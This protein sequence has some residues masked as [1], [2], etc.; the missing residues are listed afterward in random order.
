[1]ERLSP[2]PEDDGSRIPPVEKRIYEKPVAWL[3]GRQLLNS[4]KGALLYSALGSKLDARDWMA[5]EVLDF[6]DDGGEDEFWFDYLSDTGDGVM[7]VYSL[8]Y[9]SMSDLW[10]KSPWSQIAEMKDGDDRVKLARDEGFASKLPRGRFLFVGGDTAYHASDYSTLAA[11]FQLPFRWAFADLFGAERGKEPPF[12]RPLV[13]IPANH[14]YYDQLDGYRRQFRA[15]VREEKCGRLYV[16]PADPETAPQLMLPGHRRVQKASYVALKLPFG[17]WM[18]GLDTDVG[19][20][21]ERQR[22]FFREIEVERGRSVAEG[23]TPDKL[24]VATCAPTTVF[25]KYADAAADTK[26]A[27]A[28]WQVG[29]ARPFLRD[30]ELDKEQEDLDKGQQEPR[31]GDDQ[32]RLD[33]SGD[34]HLYARY[35]GPPSGRRPRERAAAEQ[36][37]ADNYAS[38]V[39]GTGGAF[40][41]PSQTYLDEIQEQALYPPVTESRGAVAK[42]IFKPWKL[43]NGGGVWLV[44]FIAA[45]VI[46][47]A[48]TTVPS[49]RDVLNNFH[50]DNF[51]VRDFNLWHAVGF[52]PQTE[53]GR[54]LHAKVCPTLPTRDAPGEIYPFK[55]WTTLLGVPTTRTLAETR[56]AACNQL[57]NCT[58]PTGQTGAQPAYF[59]GACA[60]SDTPDD[61]T[62]GVV[63]ALLSLVPVALGFAAHGWLLQDPDLVKTFTMWKVAKGAHA[64]PWYK[65]RPFVRSFFFV[66]LPLVLLSA[67]AL[68]TIRPYRAHI[69]PFGNSMFVLLSLVWAGS[70]VVLNLRYSDWL[71]HKTMVRKLN[72]WDWLLTWVLAV[73]AVLAVGAGV[74][75]FGRNNQ[76]AYVLTDNLFAVVALIIFFGLTFLGYSKAG[77]NAKGI[78]GKL[79]FLL[80][81]ALHGAAQMLTPFVLVRKGSW[82]TLAA[83]VVLVVAFALLGR[84]LLKRDMR[85]PL[86]LAG[87]VYAALMVSL[88]CVT[89]RL[90]GSPASY[91]ASSGLFAHDYHDG[92]SG[93]LPAIVS[94]LV[95]VVTSC[96]WLGWYLAVALSFG[97][98][99]NEAG[100]AARIERFKEFVRV[101]L[102][103]D[104]A[105]GEDTLTAYVIAV[106]EP[107][108]K[109]AELQPRLADVFTLRR[110]TAAASPEG[111]RA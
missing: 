63:L 73:Y 23:A 9:L 1:M 82:L 101:R 53:E 48:A 74:W 5:A 70:A 21:D 3:L 71:F 93:L 94:G 35:W 90:F 25:G 104:P 45:F 87:L 12:C 95:A 100:G 59:W 29:L 27:R 99:N 64:R 40:H 58:T 67:L 38:V 96:V 98:H 61:Y 44:G 7:A 14:D 42:E 68:F 86:A 84:E 80:L 111:R 24:V 79:P 106:D 6:A 49:S 75:F 60:V 43:M 105:T 18:W 108:K 62:L 4:F 88:P 51:L 102:A 65:E 89:A 11:R 54:P 55:L 77:E 2:P 69:T 97:G 31:L 85:W 8:A 20:V 46:Y 17:W 52:A 83:A 37:R 91:A 109:G 32:L 30:E 39:S 15:P 33:L 26:A 41:H 50:L 47:F 81:G 10:V 78:A 110:K 92:W 36:P 22:K 76:M 66:V 103:R 28:F 107:K 16:N 72:R 57:P 19:E 56:T 13:G 34:I